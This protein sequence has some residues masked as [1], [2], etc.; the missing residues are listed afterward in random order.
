MILDRIYSAAIISSAEYMTMSLSGISQKAASTMY[1]T[2]YTK[3]S[4]TDTEPNSM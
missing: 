1:G 4:M 3:R 2:E